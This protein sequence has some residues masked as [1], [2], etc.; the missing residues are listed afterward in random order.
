MRN[1]W[2]LIIAR[3]ERVIFLWLY[4]HWQAVHVLLFNLISMCMLTGLIELNE[5]LIKKEHGECKVWKGAFCREQFKWE[6]MIKI[7]YE[8]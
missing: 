1:L 3:E 8:D 7:A 5:V 2:Q 4:G 6:D